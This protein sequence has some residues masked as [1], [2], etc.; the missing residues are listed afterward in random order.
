MDT[1]ALVRVLWFF[2][3]A[4]AANM[5]PVLVQGHLEA[6]AG[7]IDAGRTVRGRRLLGD[8]KTWR[9]LVAGVLAGAA[10]FALQV[11]VH[12]AGLLRGLML[13]DYADLSLLTGVLLGLGTGI[14]DAL[15]SFFKRQV[16]I[17]PGASWPVF[18]QLD[19]MVGAYALVA[20]IHVPPVVPTLASLPIVLAGGV[21]VTT[22]GW[23]LG[24]KESWM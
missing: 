21:V 2:L 13:V 15:K 11:A 24:L 3:P 22:I 9:G 5:A 14:G 17:A 10:V 18:D 6:L 7:P 23:R 1:A 19:F 20:P 4:Y 12:G 16:G 8:H